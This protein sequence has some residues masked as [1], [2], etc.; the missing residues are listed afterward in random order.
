MLF[1]GYIL[2]IV[3]LGATSPVML[4]AF[5]SWTTELRK[6]RGFF[7]WHDTAVC[8]LIEHHYFLYLTLK[9]LY[10]QT[11]T[12]SHWKES[13]YTT[14][15]TS[16]SFRMSLSV[17]H[18]HSHVTGVMALSSGGCLTYRTSRRGIGFLTG[19]SYHDCSSERT[20]SQTTTLSSPAI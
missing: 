10:K 14:V 3:A 8:A 2:K 4:E 18:R 15:K 19:D 5:N 9:A 6:L 1:C 12:Q 11:I 7:L 17:R 20:V 16:N 13:R